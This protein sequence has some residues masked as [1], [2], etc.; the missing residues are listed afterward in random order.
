MLKLIRYIWDFI[1]NLLGWFRERKADEELKIQ[2]AAAELA[3]KNR[4]AREA[5]AKKESELE[6]SVKEREAATEEKFTSD[7]AGANAVADSLNEYFG[8]GVRDDTNS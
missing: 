2:Q 4:K 7:E 8:S 6:Q 1:K 3:E 5:L